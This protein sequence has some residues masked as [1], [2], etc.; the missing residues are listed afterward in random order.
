MRRI[1]N[2]DQLNWFLCGAFAGR[3]GRRRHTSI[4]VYGL[5]IYYGQGVS[6]VK[7]GTTQVSKAEKAGVFFFFLSRSGRSDHGYSLSFDSGSSMDDRSKSF[8]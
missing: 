5:E 3:T 1:K 2:A 8:L 6:I 4:V 7:P